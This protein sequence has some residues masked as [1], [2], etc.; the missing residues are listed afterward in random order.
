[1]LNNRIH[2]YVYDVNKQK[3]DYY[4]RMYFYKEP[5]PDYDGMNDSYEYYAR[6]IDSLQYKVSIR[7]GVLMENKS[8]GNTILTLWLKHPN[9]SKAQD[10]IDKHL[11]AI[12]DI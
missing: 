9:Y 6:N 11:D 1:M 3:L 8:D 5:L 4:D 10:I 7:E 12:N 2:L